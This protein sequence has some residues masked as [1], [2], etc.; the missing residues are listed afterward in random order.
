[1]LLLLLQC[2][3]Q[4]DNDA[5]LLDLVSVHDQLVL[6]TD[7]HVVLELAMHGVLGGRLHISHVTA[8]VHA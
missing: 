6:L 7:L 5:K 2:Q 3:A 4:Q 8:R 1:M